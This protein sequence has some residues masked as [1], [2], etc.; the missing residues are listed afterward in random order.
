MKKDIIKIPKENNPIFLLIL[1]FFSDLERVKVGI[2]AKGKDIA[3]Q[4]ILTHTFNRDPFPVVKKESKLKSRV[5]K[6]KNRPE[7][8]ENKP[9][10]ND[11]E[12]FVKHRTPFLIQL[13]NIRYHKKH[14][15]SSPFWQK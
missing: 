4:R 15:I 12:F 5:N 6:I 13:H 8:T 2:S 9:K 7:K 14:I 11:F 3:R 1:A 10:S